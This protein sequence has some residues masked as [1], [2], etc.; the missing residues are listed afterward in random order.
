MK[1]NKIL[2]LRLF[3]FMIIALLTLMCDTISSI[4]GSSITINAPDDISEMLNDGAGD[5]FHILCA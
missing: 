4:T 1:H 5:D 3:G 2:L